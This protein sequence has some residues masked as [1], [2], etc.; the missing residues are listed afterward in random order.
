M[1]FRLTIIP[2]LERSTRGVKFEFSTKAEMIA[3]S[4]S[5]ADLLLFLQDKIA[6]MPDYS[7]IFT[8]EEKIDGEW[9]DGED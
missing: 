2:A 4:D 3:A 7:N 8:R 6:V 9:L 1:N 5:C